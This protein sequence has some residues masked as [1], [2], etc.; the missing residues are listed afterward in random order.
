MK[1]NPNVLRQRRRMSVWCG[2]GKKLAATSLALILLY[3]FRGMI[4]LHELN[5]VTVLQ[6]V[7]FRD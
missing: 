5:C 2:I 7:F 3:P 1:S 6:S 4:I